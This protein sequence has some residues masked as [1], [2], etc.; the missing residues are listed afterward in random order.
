MIDFNVQNIES[1]GVRTV[2]YKGWGIAPQRKDGHPA[3]QSGAR[4]RLFIAGLLI[5]ALLHASA[6]VAAQNTT[7][8]SISAPTEGQYLQGQVTVKGTTQIPDFSSA[9]VAFAYASDPTGTWFTIQTASLPVTDDTL[10]VWDTSLITDG[11]YSLR[12]RV[13]LVDG[14]SRDTTVGVRVR[15]YTPV[16]TPTAAMTA[17]QPPVLDIPTAIIIAATETATVTVAPPAS[18]PSALP[19]NPAGVTPGEIYSEFWRGALVV[20]VLVLVFGVLVRWRRQ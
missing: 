15:N 7:L 20:G 17:T 4:A 9:E 13:I 10:A 16:P 5:A 11:D 18:T 12:L 6:E 19:P 1:C 14:S 8:P 3:S 2:T